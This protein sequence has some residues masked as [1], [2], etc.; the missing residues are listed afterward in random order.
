MDDE[1]QEYFLAKRKLAMKRLKFDWRCIDPYL[2]SYRKE[3]SHFILS[4]FFY[5]SSV[6]LSHLLFR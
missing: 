4:C 1:T 3:R 5:S 2:C 6:S